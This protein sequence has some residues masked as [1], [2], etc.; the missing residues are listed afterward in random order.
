MRKEHLVVD[1]LEVCD[2]E[3]VDREAVSRIVGGNL[4]DISAGLGEDE[5]E[6]AE[7]AGPVY[8]AGG[9]RQKSKV[10]VCGARRNVADQSPTHIYTHANTYAYTDAYF[11]AY[12]CAYSYAYAYIYAYAYTYAYTYS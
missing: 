11:Y 8:E 2:R 10:S 9:R 5:R 1:P 7:G 12:A 3:H 6:G 4:G